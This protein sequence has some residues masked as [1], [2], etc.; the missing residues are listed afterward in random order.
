LRSLGEELVEALAGDLMGADVFGREAVGL[1]EGPRWLRRRGGVGRGLGRRRC[2]SELG[3][4]GQA[5]RVH[6]GGDVEGL[7]CVAQVDVDRDL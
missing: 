3:V 4:Q 1:D 6:A 7:A 2:R 5:G